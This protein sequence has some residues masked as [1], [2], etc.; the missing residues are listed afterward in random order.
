MS[1]LSNYSFTGRLVKDAKFKT[2]Q[3]GKSVLEM[4]V[5]VNTGYGQYK[6]TNWISVQMWG[7]RGKNI[8]E[9][10]VKG[11][12]VA[13]TGELSLKPWE[14]DGKSGLNANVNASGIQLLQSKKES[15]QTAD[16]TTAGDETIF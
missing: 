8:V 15:Q 2:I 6:N 3:S 16:P 14:K 7:E 5:A 11:S 4:D 13:V 10:L 1:D 9:W 12:L